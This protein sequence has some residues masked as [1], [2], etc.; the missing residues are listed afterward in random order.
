MNS[1]P[2]SNVSKTNLLLALFACIIVGIVLCIWPVDRSLKSRKN[3]LLINTTPNDVGKIK[4]PVGSVVSVSLFAGASSEMSVDS[5]V[6]LCDFISTKYDL[7]DGFIILHGK[8]TIPYSA[9]SLFFCYENN[10]K[11]IVFSA[12][13]QED[14]NL[15]YKK[16]QEE[17]GVSYIIDGRIGFV[18]HPYTPY[19]PSLQTNYKPLSN[20]V[21]VAMRLVHPNM[22][23]KLPETQLLILV[24][25]G[26]GEVPKGLTASMAEFIKKGGYICIVGNEKKQS[27][28]LYSPWPPE[29]TFVKLLWILSTY[30][31]QELG[32]IQKRLA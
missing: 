13:S 18:S 10:K 17:A 23:L 11:P 8:D 14:A 26:S 21:S 25:Y 28:L 7:F 6:K 15:A 4:I 2:M 1:S 22:E 9:A 12:F 19:N 16:V 32:E 27:G 29:V 5:L 20:S 3:I 24:S 30:G 31:K